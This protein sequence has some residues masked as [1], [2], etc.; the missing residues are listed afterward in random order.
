MGDCGCKKNKGYVV[1]KSNGDTVTVT[2]EAEAAS[3][4]DRTQGTYRSKS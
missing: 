4:A 2:T 3:L 1:T